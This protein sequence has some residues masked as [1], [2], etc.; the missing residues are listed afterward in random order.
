VVL[1]RFV[2]S[3]QRLA[4]RKGK[5]RDT[6]APTTRH[7]QGSWLTHGFSFLY[8]FK[9]SAVLSLR[10]STSTTQLPRL[11]LWGLRVQASAHVRVHIE[12]VCL[13]CVNQLG[14]TTAIITWYC[15]YA[16]LFFFINAPRPRCPL[17]EVIATS[18]Q[19]TARPLQV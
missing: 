11:V 14:D 15:A 19:L 1:S 10:L 7:G 9:S 13:C 16:L 8:S 5:A 17:S 6:V 12:L 18:S 3:V 4:S 2:S